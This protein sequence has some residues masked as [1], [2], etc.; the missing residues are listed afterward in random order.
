[1]ALIASANAA[2]TISPDPMVLAQEQFAQIAAYQCRI[3]SRTAQGDRTLMRY[4]YRK[5]GY[6]R[7][8]FSEPHRGAVLIYDPDSGKVRVWPFG[9]GTLP[10]LSLSPSNSLVQDPNGH[11]VDQSDVGTLLRNIHRL[12]QGGKT[13]VVGKETLA[14]QGALHVTILGVA[15]VSVDGV[16][17]YEVWLEESHG[18]PTKV[19]SYDSNDREMETVMMDALVFNLHFP[20]DFFTP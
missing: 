12:Q 3:D 7:M 16:H 13:T 2:P 9:I 5:P 15:G 17:R 6:V 18:F 19:V 8:D 20:A 1:M 10:V 4:S 11:R 14:G